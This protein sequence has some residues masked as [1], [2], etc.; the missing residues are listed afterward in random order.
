MT[1]VRRWR[2]VFKRVLVAATV[3]AALAPAPASAEVIRS[4]EIR[5]LRQLSEETVLYYLG[6][7]VGRELDEAT[8]NSSLLELWRRSLVD[9]ISVEKLPEADGV[10]IVVTIVERPVLR[11]LDFKGLKR[12]SRTD[13]NDRIAKDSISVREGLPLSLGEVRRLEGAI[14]EMYREKGFRFAEAS[15]VLEEV[16]PT[17]RRVVFTIDEAEKVR[18]GE[19]DFGGN[20]VYGDWR[21]KWTMSKTKETNLLWRMMKRDIYN[22]ATLNEDLIKVSELYRGIGYKN[23]TVNDP[24]L[25]VLEKRSGTRRL[26]LELPVVEGNRFTLGEIKIEGNEVFPE[27]FLHNQFGT[28]RGGWLRSKVLEKGSESINEAYRNFGHIF[29]NIDTELVEV[30][31]ST[32][33]LLVRISEGD[34]YRVGRMEFEGNSRTHDKVLRREFRVQEGTLLN[35]GAVKNSLFKV[36]QLG[37]FK[38]KEDDPILFENFDTEKK[39]VDLRIQGDE[40]DRTELQV[41]AGWSESYGFFGQLSVRTQN[42]MGRGETFG[43]SVQSGRYQD[44]YSLSY[45]I[46]WFLDRPQSIGLQVFKSDLNYSPYASQESQRESEGFVLTYGRNLGLFSSL[47]V[48]FNRSDLLDRLSFFGPDGGTLTQV[49][50]ISNSSIQPGFLFDSRD[51]RLETTRGMK[52]SGSIEYAGGILSGDNNFWRPEVNFSFFQPIPLGRISSVAAINAEAGW[53]NG[54]GDDEVIPLER[55][56][57]GGENSVRGFE[58]RSI[59]VRDENDIPVLEDGFFKGGDKFLQL[60]LEYHFLLGG[61]FRVLG[62]FDAGNVYDEDQSLDPSRMRYSAGVEL[63]IFVPVF[64]APLR[65]IYASNLEPFP[66]DQFEAFQFSIG[67]TF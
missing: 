47:S 13:I 41:G 30:D 46:P 25:G 60:N 67:A 32:A 34:Q 36:N 61:P 10:R 55:Y 43:V 56:Y 5:G 57:L 31:D 9:D 4:V 52:F 29:A 53:V 35:M 18:I 54:F 15:F 51:S 22:P 58:F 21:L 64:G 24:L 7:Q 38:L 26:A 20:E 59:F 37:Y 62:F 3:V 19:I 12:L 27:K 63:R 44:E 17:E 45:F 28:P 2:L 23:F 66:N 39:T 48:S 49:Y 11:S 33:D 8:L 14:E 1:Q 40:A 42:F 6:L 65:F 50:D 16:S